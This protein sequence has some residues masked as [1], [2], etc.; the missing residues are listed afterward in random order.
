MKTSTANN[1][2]NSI[3]K[4]YD[5]NDQAS[6][7]PLNFS[8]S[9]IVRKSPLDFSKNPPVFIATGFIGDSTIFNNGLYQN[10]IILAD[11]M[12]LLN[13][14]PVLVFERDPDI[15]SY[16][17]ARDVPI[18]TPDSILQYGRDHAQE[19]AECASGGL[20][21]EV[22]MSISGDFR[23]FIQTKFKAKTVKL[24]LGNIVNI[25][26]ETPIM[27]HEIFFNHHVANQTD[28][29]QEIWT[30]PH[31]LSNLEYACYINRLYDLNNGKIMPYIWSKRFS[32]SLAK[33]SPTIPANNRDIV[34]CEPNIS[35]QKCF[36]Y[37]LLLAEAY[38]KYN[39]EWKGNVVLLNFALQS[40]ANV[41]VNHTVIKNMNLAKQ[42]RIVVEKQRKSIVD[43]TGVY[44]GKSVVYIG[45]QYNNDYNYM[46][47]ELMVSCQAPILHNSAGWKDYGYYWNHGDLDSSLKLLDNVM[48]YHETNLDIY[49]VH[50]EQ[51]AW[52]HSVNNPGVQREYRELI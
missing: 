39:P 43:I 37:P 34:I 40:E 13:R 45:H 26:I 29:I 7:P 49:R 15:S 42:G 28:E 23:K 18:M 25:D 4:T 38:S 47:L 24:Y 17:I 32:E 5:F 2:G 36:F 48:K 30:S 16:R 46:T 22:G 10:A 41:Y 31:Y 3:I 50:G 44:N 12:K 20:Y 51:L 21:I 8:Q 35:M 1:P 6:T 27:M 19:I 52:N 9:P 11:M 14:T 33:W